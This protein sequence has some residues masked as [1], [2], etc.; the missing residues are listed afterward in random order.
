MLIDPAIATQWEQTALA[1]LGMDT[2][3][4]LLKW[5]HLDQNLFPYQGKPQ[6]SL[7]RH[8]LGLDEDPVSRD[9]LDA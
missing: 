4:G 7:S 6:V 5:S 9:R 8:Q 2:E 3:H 1:I